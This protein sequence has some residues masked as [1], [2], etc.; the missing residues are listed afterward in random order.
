MGAVFHSDGHTSSGAF[1]MNI[2]RHYKQS[3][4]NAF[5][6]KQGSFLLRGNF[7]GK[8]Q[9]GQNKMKLFVP[10]CGFDLSLSRLPF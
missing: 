3:L 9:K 4:Q 10:F 7:V 5:P 8:L 2:T 6:R 1:L